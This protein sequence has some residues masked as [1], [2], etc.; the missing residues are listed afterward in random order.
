MSPQVVVCVI[1]DFV[2]FIY[3]SFSGPGIGIQEILFG[4]MNLLSFTLDCL[5]ILITFYFQLLSLHVSFIV[6]SP[7]SPPIS[8]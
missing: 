8:L 7:G 4:R 2:F 1:R 5:A 6:C 3:E